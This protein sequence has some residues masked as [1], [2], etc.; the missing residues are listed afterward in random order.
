ME[1]F[2]VEQ[3]TDRI[4]NSREVMGLSQIKLLNKM[5]LTSEAQS[6]LS[7]IE[8]GKYKKGNKSFIT[9]TM[10]DLL[11]EGLEM[12]KEYIV[13]GEEKERV[14]LI[15]CIFDEIAYNLSMPKE[16][17]WNEKIKFNKELVSISEKLK[18]ILFA[19]A[20]FSYMY[21]YNEIEDVNYLSDVNVRL[22]DFSEEENMIFDDTV[23]LF[24][25]LLKDK[26]LKSFNETFIA[27]QEDIYMKQLNKRIYEWLNTDVIQIFNDFINSLHEDEL[28]NIG[29]EVKS[30]MMKALDLS[31]KEMLTLEYGEFMYNSTK[32]DDNEIRVLF[33]KNLLEQYMSIAFDLKEFQK[34]YIKLNSNN[35]EN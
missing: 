23:N 3:V 15:R 20:E 8:N 5:G 13:F 30:E 18:Q 26:L 32:L 9:N 11:S 33:Q 6:D 34:Q 12:K 19:Y 35:V 16:L 22:Y 24:F 29:Y 1:K 14:K 4:K 31:Q 21:I 27:N 7:K 2:I 10:L 17:K 28:M 25:N